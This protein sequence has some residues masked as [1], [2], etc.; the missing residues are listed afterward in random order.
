MRCERRDDLV[1][2]ASERTHRGAPGAA[3]QARWRARG[4]DSH[5]RREAA[6]NLQRPQPLDVLHPPILNPLTRLAITVSPSGG[7]SVVGWDGNRPVTQ[8]GHSGAA[9]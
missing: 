3:F 4:Y 2:Y 6:L 9:S 7:L 1:D 5:G 8:I